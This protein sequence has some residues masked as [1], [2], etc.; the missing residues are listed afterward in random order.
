MKHLLVEI[1]PIHP[2]IV[3]FLII[4]ISTNSLHLPKILGHT[5]ERDQAAESIIHWG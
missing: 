4:I 2:P 1:E 3:S 5:V